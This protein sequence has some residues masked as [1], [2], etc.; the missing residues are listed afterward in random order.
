[1]TGVEKLV[2]RNVAEGKRTQSSVLIRLCV[3]F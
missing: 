3:F 2:A 1:M